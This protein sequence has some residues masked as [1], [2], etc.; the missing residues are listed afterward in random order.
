MLTTGTEADR[1]EEGEVEASPGTGTWKEPL[2]AILLGRTG[3]IKGWWERGREEESRH[4]EDSIKALS[5]AASPS[6]RHH[7]STDL[8]PL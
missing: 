7:T 2:E 8:V 1:D 5:S 4:G 6:Y 3:Y